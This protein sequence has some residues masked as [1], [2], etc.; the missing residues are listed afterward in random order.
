[1]GRGK[2]AYLMTFAVNW[3]YTWNLY[4]VTARFKFHQGVPETSKTL[5]SG[6]SSSQ[7][8]IRNIKVIWL[9]Y[10]SH[11]NQC[12]WPPLSK[13]FLSHSPRPVL[14]SWNRAC[15]EDTQPKTRG[16]L[17]SQEYLSSSA[18]QLKVPDRVIHKF[19]FHAQ[20]HSVNP[21]A[22]YW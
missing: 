16:L 6:S 17:F 2:G 3:L 15:N 10:V 5:F 19:W 9:Q 13:V 4:S 14:S 12:G 20:N 1:M 18:T 22:L 21:T 7:S 11:Q 8:Q